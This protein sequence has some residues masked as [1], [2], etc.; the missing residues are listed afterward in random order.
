MLVV[1]SQIIGAIAA[2]AVV[3]GLFPGPMLFRTTLSSDPVTSLERG[4]FIEMFL[5]AQLIFT[6]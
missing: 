3:S 1:F 4:V 2:A 6:M 5:T